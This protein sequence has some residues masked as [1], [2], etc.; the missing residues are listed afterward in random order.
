MAGLS[1]GSDAS[2][3]RGVVARSEG[4]RLSPAADSNRL[5]AFR[6]ADRSTKDPHIVAACNLSGLFGCEA[7]AQHRRDEL[8]PLRVILHAAGED[9]LVGANAD[10]IDPDDLGHLFEPVDIFIEAREE[11]WGQRRRSQY[12]RNESAY[13][14]IAAGE[15]TSRLV[16]SV[17]IVLQNSTRSSWLAI[18]ESGRTQF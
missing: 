9:L 15:Q 13:P 3:L 14:P 10:V 7:A 4:R 17:P 1:R 6:S 12:V 5:Q 18:I 8:H 11:A 2:G 16:G